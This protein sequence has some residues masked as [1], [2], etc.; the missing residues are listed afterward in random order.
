M[1]PVIV[2]ASF[3]GFAVLIVGLIVFAIRMDKKR[4]EQWRMIAGDMNF[5]FAE[6]SPGPPEGFGFKIF[7]RGHSKRRKNIL[8]GEAQGLS[9]MMCDYRYTTGSGKNASTHTQTICIIRDPDIDLPGIFVRREHGFLDKIGQM[10]GGQD[11]DFE[12]DPAFSKAFVLQGEEEERIRQVFTPEVRNLFVEHS[13]KFSV[14][15][16]DRDTIMVQTGR[17]IKPEQAKDLMTLAF[18]I[19]QGL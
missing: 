15:E 1:V 18:S 12:D 5:E 7:T 4:T 14:F 11:I 13:K 17:Y 9:V 6:K 19:K 10:F 2:I 16:A 8:S 3:A